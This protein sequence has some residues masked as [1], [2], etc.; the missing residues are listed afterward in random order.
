MEIS[1]LINRNSAVF[2]EVGLFLYLEFDN[3]SA[4]RFYVSINICDI[5][6]FIY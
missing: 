5:T 4:V 2:I 1:E 6:K 3:H